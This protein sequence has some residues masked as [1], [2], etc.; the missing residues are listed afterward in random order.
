MAVDPTLI[1]ANT[2]ISDATGTHTSGFVA[3]APNGPIDTLPPLGSISLG[4]AS[5]GGNGYAQFTGVGQAGGIV[6]DLNKDAAGNFGP[7]RTALLIGVSV[8]GAY[9][10]LLFGYLV[11]DWIGTGNA[12]ASSMLLG[13]NSYATPL[14][15]ALV[16]YGAGLWTPVPKK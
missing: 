5:F 1:S 9:L 2:T 3:V 16:A 7:Y 14:L 15:A 4:S 6:Q 10:L 12:R 13:L 11:G 8:A